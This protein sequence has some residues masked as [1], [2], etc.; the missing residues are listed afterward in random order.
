MTSHKL[1]PARTL[2]TDEM[3]PPKVSEPTALPVS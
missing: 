1:T 3:I 2:T